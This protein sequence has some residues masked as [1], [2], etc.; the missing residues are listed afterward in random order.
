[1]NS[2]NQNILATAVILGLTAAA[3]GQPA[4]T[5]ISG[6]DC[7]R[8]RRIAIEGTGFGADETTGTVVIGGFGALTSTWTDSRIVAYVPETAPIGTV[9]MYVSV[10]DQPSNEVFINVT[11]RQQVGRVKWIFEADS[12][13]IKYRPALAPDGTLYIHTSNQTD[14]LVYALAPNGALLWITKVNWAPYG[15]PSAGPDGAVYVGSIGSA[16]RISP[17]GNIDWEFF[18]EAIGDGIFV[19]PHAGPDGMV[20]GAYQ[21]GIGAYS[22][23]PASGEAAWTNTGDPIMHDW[24][25][26]QGNELV[27]GWSGAGAP[28]DRFFVTMEWQAD[29]HCMTLDGEQLWA[30]GTGN[31]AT[32]PA[33]GSDGTVYLP[34]ILARY[35]EALD[36]DTGDSLWLF[37]PGGSAQIRGIE[38]DDNDILYYFAS[39]KLQALDPA[40]GPSLV[41]SISTGTINNE[42]SLTPDGTTLLIS[43][44]PNYGDPGFIKAYSAA[45][46]QEVW[47]I[48][49]PG[50]PSPADRLIGSHHARITPD[51]STAYMSTTTLTWDITPDT[52]SF[53]YAIDLTDDPGP[54]LLGDANHDGRVNVDDIVMVVTNWGPCPAAPLT[55][56]ADLDGNGQVDIDDI[57]MVVLH[58]T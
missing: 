55:C 43:G 18:P 1:M 15:P 45:N 6:T 10:L 54:V 37:Q 27:F 7:P 28:V 8:S 50:A 5:S 2:R 12:N 14:G 20:Y 58:W 51:G 3:L 24:A 34:A 29:I 25:G 26:H 56:D 40:G 21:H 47:H 42:P 13:Q 33:I 53:V 17:E 52:T 48:D 9:P 23:H 22:L 57:T 16:Y 46:G 35:V 41:W 19:V 11:L 31:E 44:V 4:I 38:I 49:L 36:P 39:G 30:R 32:E